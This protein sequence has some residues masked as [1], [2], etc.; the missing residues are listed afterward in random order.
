MVHPWAVIYGFVL[1]WIAFN[2]IL[3]PFIKKKTNYSLNKTGDNDEGPIFWLFLFCGPFMLLFLKQIRLYRKHRYL[4]LRIQYY[5][6]SHMP[7]SL[8]DIGMVGM[9]PEIDKLER[10]YKISKI[11]QQSRRNK[12]KKKILCR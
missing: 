7:I 12:I 2:A 4:K 11:H 3:I 9:Q 1:L 10:I 5:K 6:F 8:N